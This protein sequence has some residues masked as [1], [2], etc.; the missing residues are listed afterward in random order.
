MTYLELCVRARQE[1]GISGGGPTTVL[2]QTGQLLKVVDWVSFAWVEIQQM[3]PNWL[4]MW[5]EFTFDTIID[6]R[7]YDAAS[8]AAPITNLKLWDVDSFL[9]YETALTEIDQNALLYLNYQLWR[10]RNREQ[11]NVRSAD[12][13]Q[14]FT[15]LPDNKVRFEPKPDKVYTIDGEYKRSTQQFVADADVPTNLPDDFHMLIVW[16]ALKNYAWH[17]DAAEVMDQAETNFDNL[18]FR[19][20]NEQ[21]MDM[22]EDFETLA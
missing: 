13:P 2:N 18:L 21:L 20:E 14:Q 4:F 15:L 11:M 9:I 10:V 22:S 3:R 19:L 16:Q 6:Q 17:E 12:R 5:E 7:D 8:L 1:S